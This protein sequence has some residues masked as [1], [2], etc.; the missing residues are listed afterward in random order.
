MSKVPWTSEELAKL[1]QLTEKYRENKQNVNWD[2]VSKH[3]Q[4]RTA[5][6]CK[7][8][9][10][11]ILKKQLNVEI[12]QNHMWNYIEI[13]ALWTYSVIY[14]QDFAMIH[15]RFMPKFTVKQL[16]SQYQQILRNQKQ[17]IKTFNL[18]NTDPSHR[19]ALEQRFQAALEAL[20]GVFQEIEADRHQ[21]SEPSGREERQVPDRLFRNRCVESVFRGLRC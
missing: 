21:N 2:Q 16:T 12:R 11:N 9:Y 7:S 1:T 6:Q 17:I 13:L 14:K 20:V 5:S 8:Y 18:L 3:I 4:S 10:A 15:D 19:A